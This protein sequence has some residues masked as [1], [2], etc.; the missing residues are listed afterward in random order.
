MIKELITIIKQKWFWIGLLSPLLIIPIINI[1]L[2]LNLPPLFDTGLI[3]DFIKFLSIKLEYQIPAEYFIGIITIFILFF[4]FAQ[5]SY[6]RNSLPA[7]L[8][9][10]HILYHRNSALFIGLQLSLS[11]IVG[12]FSFYNSQSIHNLNFILILVIILSSVFI[13]ILY[14]Y[15]LVRNVTA[16]GMFQIIKNKLNFDEIRKI[17]IETEKSFQI[18]LNEIQTGKFNLK[19]TLFD[20]L[21]FMLDEHLSIQTDKV[22]IIKSIDLHKIDALLKEYYEGIKEIILDIKVGQRIPLHDTYPGIIPKTNLFRIFTLPSHEKEKNDIIKKLTKRLNEDRP[23]Y[24]SLIDCFDIDVQSFQFE[25]NKAH[26]NDLV[27][28]YIY[29]VEI[30]TA[31]SDDLIGHF[32]SFIFQQVKSL[33]PDSTIKL[34]EKLLIEIVERFDDKLK[35]QG[36]SIGRIE[37]TLN[38]IYSMRNAAVAGKSFLIMS[39]LLSLLMYLFGKYIKSEHVTSNRIHPIIL[40]IQEIAFSSIVY[41]RENNDKQELLKYYKS[42]YLPLVGNAIEKAAM[43]FYLLIKSEVKM[44]RSDHKILYENAQH[45][46]NFLSPIDHWDPVE[47]LKMEDSLHFKKEHHRIVK[48]H[49]ENILHLAVLIFKYVREGKLPANSIVNIAFPLV[50]NCQTIKKFQTN[51]EELLNDFFFSY[52][53]RELTSSFLQEEFEVNKVHEAGAYSPIIY[54]FRDFWLTYS[55]YKGLKAEYVRPYKLIFIP[56]VDKD[57]TTFS[58]SMVH[59][60]IKRLQSISVKELTIWLNKDEDTIRE[61]MMKYGSHLSEL[62]SQNKNI[63]FD[64]SF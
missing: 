26:L 47:R 62:F 12:F 36:L 21:G 22:G 14:F 56:S 63:L 55:I 45:L 50:D 29:A 33:Q 10:K 6:S 5:F 18:F 53:F 30:E 13:S 35:T 34:S 37:T 59:Y 42:F 41:T 24:N 8:V 46:I 51:S 11:S 64:D 1:G 28:F 32:S 4:S 60:M 38:F 58:K 9:R 31:E 54:S 49:G 27:Q 57:N 3:Y 2:I 61:I 44:E 20:Y 19:F 40:Y 16:V 48:S 15:W 7:N 39:K 25:K 17:E 52:E 43:A 23:F